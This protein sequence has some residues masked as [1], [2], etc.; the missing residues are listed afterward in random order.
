MTP[1]AIHQWGPVPQ[2]PTLR[3]MVLM[4]SPHSP[5]EGPGGI[6]LKWPTEAPITGSASLGLPPTVPLPPAS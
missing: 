3:G 5:S 2:T 4:S 1:R 6:K